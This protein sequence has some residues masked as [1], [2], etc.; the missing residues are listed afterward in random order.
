M[1]PSPGVGERGGQAATLVFGE[2]TGGADTCGLTFG[3]MRTVGVW[4]GEVEGVLVGTKKAREWD[5]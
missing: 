4:D 2:T 3:M 5:Y 1:I